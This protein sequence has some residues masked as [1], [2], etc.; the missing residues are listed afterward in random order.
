MADGATVCRLDGE[1]VSR[2]ASVVRALRG[3]LAHARTLLVDL[4]GIGASTGRASARSSACCGCAPGHRPGPGLR[5]PARARQAA[6]GRGPGPSVPLVAEPSASGRPPPPVRARER[7]ELARAAGSGPSA[8]RPERAGHGRAGTGGHDLVIVANRLPVHHDSGDSPWEPSPGGLVR[9]MLGVI[10]HYHG[11]WVGWSGLADEDAGPFEHD[12]IPLVP[13]ALSADD[14][15]DF[16]DG[17]ANDTLWP[18]YHDAIRTPT[19]EQELVGGLR[20]RQ[21]A[22]RR[23]RGRR[24]GARAPSSGS[25]TTTCSSSPRCCASAGPTCASA[26]SSTSRSR[27]RSCS[28]ACRG[29]RRSCAASSAPTWSG[30]S[31]GA[32]PRTWRCARG[33][34]ST[35]TAPCPA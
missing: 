7:T 2:E 8:E 32:R 11:A 34:C 13:V 26:S 14:V 20:Q 31:A 10:R 4:R 27:P 3:R 22:L 29:G 18:L 19:F 30:S 12:D 35:R 28:C 17:F 9:A 21:R 1:L 15:A 24:R 16:Y 6:P 5:G 33:G 25:T 23:R